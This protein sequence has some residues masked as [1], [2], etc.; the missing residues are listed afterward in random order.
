M[1]VQLACAV[2]V[3]GLG[4]MRP[5]AVGEEGA[6]QRMSSAKP[7]LIPT[8]SRTRRNQPSTPALLPH[9]GEGS[10]APFSCTKRAGVGSAPRP[11]AGEGQE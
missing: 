8:L 3:Q 1:I 10:Q 7:T 5:P 2:T 4:R 6:G 11:L 9:A